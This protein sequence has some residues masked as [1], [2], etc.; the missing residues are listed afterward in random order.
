MILQIP[1]WTGGYKDLGH[2]AKNKNRKPGSGSSIDIVTGTGTHHG[3][4]HDAMAELR[5]VDPGPRHGAVARDALC[6]R[7]KGRVRLSW[8]L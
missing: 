5:N 8:R 6:P 1:E 3:L 7:V 4:T 2:E